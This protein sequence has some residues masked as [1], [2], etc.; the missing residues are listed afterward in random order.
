[1]VG[2]KVYLPLEKLDKCSVCGRADLKLRW[3]MSCAEVWW[4]VLVML[5]SA[6]L[7]GNFNAFAD[8]LLFDPMSNKG[9]EITQNQMR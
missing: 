2:R 4:R 1:M 8:P 6:Q 3:C 5:S 9:L 7:T